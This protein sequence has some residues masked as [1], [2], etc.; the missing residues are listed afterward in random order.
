MLENY[1]YLGF[2]SVLSLESVATCQ[3]SSVY[4]HTIPEWKSHFFTCTIG[5]QGKIPKLIMASFFQGKRRESWIQ[6][7]DYSSSAWKKKTKLSLA[8]SGIIIFGGLGLRDSEEES[9]KLFIE[10]I[11]GGLGQH[12]KSAFA[13]LCESKRKCISLGPWPSRSRS[14]P[15]TCFASFSHLSSSGKRRPLVIPLQKL[16]GNHGYT[17]CK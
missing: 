1:T 6:H 11:Q 7:D 13:A 14:I 8:C 4:V 15:T 2:Y 12:Q 16:I 17:E 3:W 10:Q 9:L 5:P